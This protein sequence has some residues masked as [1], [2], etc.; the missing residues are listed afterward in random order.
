MNVGVLLI[1]Q[2]W[3]EGLSD[4]EMFRGELRLGEMVE[5]HGFDSVWTVEH[6]FDDYS[7]VPDGPQIL[8]YFAG[9]TST[10]TLGTAAVILPWNDPLRVAEKLI[11]LDH[12][13]GGRVA[14]GMG[15]G[16]ARME[17]ASFG[18]DMG[19]A[20]E[21]Y[22]E[23]AAMI[24]D[25][26]ETGVIEGD[27]PFYPQPRVEL[28]PRPS[29]P[30]KDRVWSIAMSPDSVGVAADLGVGIMSVLQHP[31]ER[32]KEAFDTYRG[33]FER[34]HGAPPT[35]TPVLSS[36]LYCS[37]DPEDAEEVSRQYL[38]RSFVA[39]ATH[40]EFGGEHFGQ[41][42][43]YT[44]YAEVSNAI[45]AAGMDAA[46]QGYVDLMPWGTP[47]QVIERL[48]EQHRVL[49]GIDV[50]VTFSFGGLP[51]DKVEDS[52]KLFAKEVLPALREL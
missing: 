41:T 14:V 6:H 46:S 13:S 7:M 49:G 28:R 44:A 3:H 26:L 23:A 16:L 32:H 29:R 9:R 42:K 11:V 10:I 43:G 8:S 47:D 36:Y 15:R 5:D 45:R 39:A 19:E 33:R 4:E 25:A 18:I 22:D 37:A 21:R 48:A 12:T 20:R 35:T 31:L 52:F 2:N 50:N 30:F 27:G 38:A 51:F 34:L 40:Y 24:V 1:F 17:Y